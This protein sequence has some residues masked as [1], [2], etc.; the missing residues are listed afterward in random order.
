MPGFLEH[1]DLWRDQ[2]I[3]GIVAGALCGYLG[4]IVILRRIV[5]VS[6][7]LGEIAGVGVV[8]AFLLAAHATPPAEPR[9]PARP[10][11][12]DVHV[13]AHVANEGA[14]PILSDEDLRDLLEGV[15]VERADVAVASKVPA[16]APA[17]QASPTEAGDGH[18]GGVPTWLHPML[19]AIVFVVVAAVAL[20]LAPRFRRITQ[21][22]VVAFAYLLAAGLVILIGSRV[23]H[24]AHEIRH[25]LYG[26]SVSLDP[27]QLWG[28]L[29][30]AAAVA[31]LHAALFKEFLFVSFDPETARVTGIPT[32]LVGVL[33]TVS[34][35]L[36]IAT[37]SRAIGALPVFAFLVLPPAAAL[38]A[39]SSLRSAFVVSA[40]LG[41]VAST[42]GYYL[43]WI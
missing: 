27:G 19:V 4:I 32:R 6:A 2:V 21:E 18:H 28:L 39:A 12:A 1:A 36:V 24:G 11:D 7:A 43:A 8:L 5:F 41:A 22:S 35:G 31:A 9:E 29:G 33:L 20:S 14:P 30:A 38:L 15:G 25:V 16:Q 42:L 37:A 3:A 26:D 13:H 34:I 23:P 17:P 10:A 40:L